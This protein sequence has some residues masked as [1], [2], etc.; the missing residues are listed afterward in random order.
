M[1]KALK[2]TGWILTGIVAL[3]AFF[4]LWMLIVA[5]DHP[6]SVDDKSALDNER[7][8]AAKDLYLVGNNWLRK[9]ESGLW[10]MYVEGDAFE[11]GVAFGKL[12][13]ELIL[14]Q[15]EAFFDQIRELVPSDNY[16]RF[17]KY[18]LA[19]FNRDLDKSI[20]EE[21]RTEIYGLSFSCSPRFNFIG[22]GYQRQLNYHAAHDI[23]H[24]L[25]NLR[26]VGCTSFSVWNGA[27]AD[28]S[29]L[30]A[31]NFDFYAGSRFAENKI[32]CFYNPDKGHKFMMISWAGMTGVVSGMNETGLTV[33][34]NASGS[35]IPLKAS[36]PVSIVAREIL[37]YAS[38]VDEAFEIADRRKMFVSESILIGSAADGRSS[39]IEKSP[40]KTAL[41]SPP[42]NK[43]VCANHFQGEAFSNDKRNIN[44]IS[45]SDSRYRFERMNEL[46]GRDQAI[47]VADAVSI[48]RD[49]LGPGDTDPGL[50]NPM[51]INQLIAHHSVVFKPD[52]RIAWISTEPY[53]L[54]KF[55]AYNLDSIFRLAPGDILQNHEIYEPDMTVPED[56]FLLTREYANFIRHREM[57]RELADKERE[58]QTLPESFEETYTSTNPKLYSV[59]SDLGDYWFEMEEYTKAYNYYQ[60]A[61]TREIPGNNVREK[62]EGLLQESQKKSADGK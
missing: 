11:R 31:R 36:T 13:E 38:S 32:V 6:P 16:L 54:G 26:L 25:Q 53:Q 48:L 24:A 52:D 62:L 35:S 8:R 29:L 7:I 21:Y 43:V 41:F 55:V 2:I 34:I 17:L 9:S 56:T 19:W 5:V 20:P 27:S 40:H 58:K 59:W 37:Q 50:G 61:L 47:D 4:V 15:E 28:T 49:R 60:T 22:S 10:E 33:T 18:F 46:L 57:S 3:F 1:K 30:V 39:I 14:Y 42:G 44:T 23:G 12:T 51:A 45:G